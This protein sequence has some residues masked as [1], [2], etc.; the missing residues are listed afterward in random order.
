MFW[1]FALGII[2]LAVFHE[3]FRKVVFWTAGTA[4]TLIALL[5][6]GHA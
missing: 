5:V 1:L 3:G 4:T 2:A 6:W